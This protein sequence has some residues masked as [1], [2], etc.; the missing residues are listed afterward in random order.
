MSE[1]LKESSKKVE[2]SAEQPYTDTKK[3]KVRL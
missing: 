3:P 1:I 2:Y